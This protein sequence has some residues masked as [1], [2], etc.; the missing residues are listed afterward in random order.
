[1]KVITY[2]YVLYL[3]FARAEFII[4]L[5]EVFSYD[6]IVNLVKTLG[7]PTTRISDKLQN[8]LKQL[9]CENFMKLIFKNLA[10]QGK[11]IKDD[12]IV[13]YFL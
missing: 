8:Y 9:L 2:I 3:R 13:D 11:V 7:F 4:R 6:A 1:M 12:T 5:S 10:V